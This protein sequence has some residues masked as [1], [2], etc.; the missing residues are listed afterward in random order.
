MRD[1]DKS[2]GRDAQQRRERRHLK[3]VGGKDHDMSSFDPRGFY[4]DPLAYPR[5]A[6]WRLENGAKVPKQLN[7]FTNAKSDDPSTWTT[8]ARAEAF[9]KIGFML[10]YVEEAG[11]YVCG[12]DCD[13]CLNEGEVTFPIVK[14]IVARFG[15]NEVSVS[16]RGLHVMFTMSPADVEWA[17]QKYGINYRKV[18]IPKNDEHG[19]VALDFDHRFYTFMDDTRGEW[20]QATRTD[21]EWLFGLREEKAGKGQKD[22][23]GS[24]Y[25]WDFMRERKAAGDNQEQAT[26]KVLKDKGP[27]GEWARRADARQLANAWQKCNAKKRDDV[28]PDIICDF[29][30][31]NRRMVTGSWFGMKS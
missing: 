30:S 15:L 27:A 31:S 19:E 21:I 7:G 8:R 12:L 10:G 4:W 24:G 2:N 13:K 5:Y 29:R 17:R 9:D 25:G 22:F 18:V 28:A 23:S 14:Q 16:G 26:A 3:V 6:R 11:E 20:R 1:H